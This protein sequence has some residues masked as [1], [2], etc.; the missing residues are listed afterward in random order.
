MY[1]YIYVIYMIYSIKHGVNRCSI[2]IESMFHLNILYMCYMYI[3][4]YIYIT[5]YINIHTFFSHYVITVRLK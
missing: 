5:Y 1:I 4:I 3:Y 2:K